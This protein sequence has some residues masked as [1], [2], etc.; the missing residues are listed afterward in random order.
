MKVNRLLTA[1][2]FFSIILYAEPIKLT[3]PF[4][5]LTIERESKIDNNSSIAEQKLEDENNSTIRLQKLKSE[6]KNRLTSKNFIFKGIRHKKFLKRFYRQNSYTPLWITD[7]GFNGKYSSLFS[8]IESDITL[9]SNSKIYKEYNYLT[10]YIKEKKED[11]LH[12]EL[13]LTELYLDFLKHTLYGDIH[14]KN[15]S[16]KLKAMRKKGV[17][18]RWLRYSPQYNLSELL[19]QPDISETMEEITPKRFGYTGLLKA[20]IK[21]RTIKEDGG[22][23][24]LPDFKKL[25][26]GDSG[27]NV[28]KLRE[29]LTAS[30]DLVVCQIPLEKLFE[31]ESTET[32]GVESKVKIQ[33][34][35]QFD[36]CLEDAVKK[37]QKRHGLVEDGI[38]GKGTRRVLNHSVE[39]KIE[40]VLLNLN[41]IKWLPR[42]ED[43]RYL[44]A[45]IP[46]YMLHYIEGGIEKKK[47]KIIVGDR[48]HHTPIFTEKISYIVLNPYWKVPEGIVKREIIP[49]MIRNPNYLRKEGLEIHTTWY[50]RSPKIN[51]YNLYWPEYGYGYEFGRVKFPYRIMQ[52]PGPKNALGKIKFK[53]PNRFDVYLH[54]TPSRGLFKKTHRAFSHGCVRLDEPHSL[55]ETFALFNDSINMKKSNTILKGKR[56]VQLNIKNKIPIYL[57]Y[58]TAGY[59]IESDELEFRNDIYR[60]DKMQKSSK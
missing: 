14:W 28:L 48:K 54:D 55:L 12:I 36:I 19:L 47:L 50:E 30:K 5:S 49:A 38:V 51:P 20:L 59:N 10:K 32:E 39:S 8:E 26:L 57:I 37:F 52:P 23:E 41:R 40:T 25:E 53:F 21:L 27:L 44:I 43:E 56:K 42:D 34:Q 2:V 3:N 6:L 18:A 9:N 58:L 17:A 31:S 15:F 13:K 24:T 29:R 16:R 33:P 22:W 7:N 35:A 60:Y 11:R 45:N 4:D 1:T 46:E